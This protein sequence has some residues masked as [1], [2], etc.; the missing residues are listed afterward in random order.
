VVTWNLHAPDGELAHTTSVKSEF[1]QRSKYFQGT[2]AVGKQ[3]PY[4]VMESTWEFPDK[5]PHEAMVEELLDN[6]A[7]GGAVNLPGMLGKFQGKYQPLPITTN[8]AF[9]PV[10]AGGAK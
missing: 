2:K 5:D 3:G 6:A 10:A 9:P 4:T 1:D 8:A 7:R